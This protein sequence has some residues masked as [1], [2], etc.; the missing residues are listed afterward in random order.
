MRLQ[1]VTIQ[2]VA[3]DC[4]PLCGGGCVAGCGAVCLIGGF[5]MIIALPLSALGS[6]ALDAAVMTL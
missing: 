5:A 3:G 4:V 2:S 6:V 1:K